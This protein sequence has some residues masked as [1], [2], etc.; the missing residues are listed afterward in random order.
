MDKKKP[1]LKQEER[2][3]SFENRLKRVLEAQGK[4]PAIKSRETLFKAEHFKPIVFTPNE[5]KRGAKTSESF[6][7]R[8]KR[9]CKDDV[10]SNAFS[11]VQKGKVGIICVILRT[12]Y[13]INLNIFIIAFGDK[14]GKAEAKKLPELKKKPS[15][16]SSARQSERVRSAATTGINMMSTA[17]ARDPITAHDDYV[18][19]RSSL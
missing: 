8:M 12:D 3:V 7:K 13:H 10:T 1:A 5:L 18:G 16:P 6:Y 19:L 15:L 11:Y 17:Q 2:V 4:V 9:R 14:H